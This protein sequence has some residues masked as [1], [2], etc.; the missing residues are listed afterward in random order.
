M[1]PPDDIVNL[2][3]KKASQSTCRY[4]VS[5][6]GLDKRGRVLG[7]Q[8]NRHRL[9]FKGGGVHAEIALIRKYGTKLKSIIICRTNKSGDLLDIH[10]CK[11]CSQVADKLNIKIYSI[12]ELVK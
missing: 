10:S 6:V 12:K 2:A 3:Q 7:C 11:A 4:K 1:I 5:A 9:P 8:M